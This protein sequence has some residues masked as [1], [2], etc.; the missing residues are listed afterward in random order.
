MNKRVS[1]SHSDLQKKEKVLTGLKL[2]KDFVETLHENNMLPLKSASVEILQINVGKLCNQRCVHCHVNAGPDRK[3]IMRD[4]VFDKIIEILENND[5]KTLDITGGAP[6]LHPRFRELIRCTSLPGRKVIDRCNFTAIMTNPCK[7][8]P[9]LLAEYKVEIV[10]SLPC[11]T[12]DNTDKQRGA[13][14]FRTSIKLL[15]SLG[16]G[17]PDSGLVLNLVY[18]PAGAFLPP[19]EK[20]LEK[21][22]KE[23]LKENYDIVFNNLFA[24]TNLPIGRFLEFLYNTDKLEE[25]M[26]LLVNS[27]N[28][29]TVKSLMCRN[30]VSVSWDGYLYNCDF[31]QILDI[32]LD[33]HLPQ[34]VFDWNTSKLE[35]RTIVTGKHCYGCTAGAGSSCGGQIA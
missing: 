2:T 10:G 24:F 6:E 20:E 28:P 12:K 23:K 21:T 32:H 31:N 35:K 3:E 4:N 9:E 8:I 17:I 33:K 26:T 5:I 27:F 18:N 15:N 22:Y 30:M 1:L 25:Y 11:Y 7:D 29:E 16:Y 19:D 34:T 13:G 14:V